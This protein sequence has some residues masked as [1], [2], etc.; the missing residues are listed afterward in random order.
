MAGDAA[1]IKGIVCP[2]RSD[3]N[4]DDVRRALAETEERGLVQTYEPKESVWAPVR[5]LLQV[6]DWWDY[7]HL[8]DPQPSKYPAP[9]GWRDR[10]GNQQ[11]DQSGRYS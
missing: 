8:R 4:E 6:L 5:Q 7:Q 3:I 9:T 10:V 2:L 11:R 1:T